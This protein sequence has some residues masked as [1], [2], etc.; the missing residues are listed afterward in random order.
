MVK[1]SF[2]SVC[3][4]MRWIVPISRVLILCFIIYFNNHQLFSQVTRV[5]Q[6]QENQTVSSSCKKTREFPVFD[7]KTS[8]TRL[9]KFLKPGSLQ[10]VND[11]FKNESNEVFGVFLQR[12]SKSKVDSLLYWEKVYQLS[13]HDSKGKWPVIS[14]PVP[15][16]GAILPFHRIVAFYGNIYSK[17]MGVLG[18]YPPVE[19]WEKLNEEVNKWES[20]DSLTPVIPALHYVAVVAQDN[21]LKDGKYRLRMPSSQIDSV[22][23]IAQMG[24]ALV[25]LDIQPGLSDVQTEVPLLEKY[26]KLPNVHL[27]LDPEFSMK[28]GNVPGTVKGFVTADD[29]NFCSEFLTNLVYKYK[30]PPKVFIVHRFTQ[31]MIRNYEQIKLHPEVQIVI[32]MD[33][34][35]RPGLK[36]STYKDFIYQEPIQFTGFKLFYDNDLIQFPNRIMKPEE[37]L[38]LT[39]LPIY[40]QYQ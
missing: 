7:K 9:S 14:Q 37:I 34:W 30:I 36:K 15:Y 38:K 8:K 4:N 24:N 13:I 6:I 11:C 28:E 12:L 3:G 18:K 25:F 16:S 29:I 23:E 1:I 21:P 2:D 33:G 19:L 22:L 32:N 35:G 40:I 31:S 17:K 39:P 20:A 27:G 10:I 5:D 26:L